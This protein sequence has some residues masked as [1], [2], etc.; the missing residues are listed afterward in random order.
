MLLYACIVPVTLIGGG[1]GFFNWM[2]E[3]SSLH[4]YLNS[5]RSGSAGKLLVRPLDLLLAQK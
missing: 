1:F 5:T 4:F 3:E 2:R